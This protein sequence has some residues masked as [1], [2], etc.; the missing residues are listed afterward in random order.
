M[1]IKL[2]IA[3]LLLAPFVSIYAD[4]ITNDQAVDM[5]KNNADEIAIVA[6]MGANC[7]ESIDGGFFNTAW[8]RCSRFV[9]AFNEVYEHNKGPID[10]I[11]ELPESEIDSFCGQ[12]SGLRDVC[13][14]VG[15]MMY[16]Y[17]KAIRASELGA[18]DN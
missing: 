1:K 18:F 12:L 8:E 11:Y 15:I 9:P 17:Q 14:D 16:S 10:Y 6:R 13:A 2:G 5:L 7:T 4:S 3:T